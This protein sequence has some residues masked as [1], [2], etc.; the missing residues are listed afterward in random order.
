MKPKQKQKKQHII[1]HQKYINAGTGEIIDT[2]VIE[3]EVENDFNF[4][5]IWLEDLMGIMDLIGGRKLDVLRYLLDRM[6]D[7]DNSIS[8][9]YTQ[10]EKELKIS[11]R[12]IA[13][14]MK[15]LQEANFIKKI[16]NGLYMVNPDIIVKGGAGKREALMIKYTKS[17]EDNMEEENVQN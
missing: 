14:T 3:K 12:T 15:I 8:V 13:E 2:V 10:M 1:G 9:T 17:N 7:V 16:Q 11:R 5:K 4:H 6:R